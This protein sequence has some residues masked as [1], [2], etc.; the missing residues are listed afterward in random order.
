MKVPTVHRAAESAFRVLHVHRKAA[1]V[2]L[3]DFVIGMIRFTAATSWNPF[4]THLLWEATLQRVTQL[5]PPGDWLQY[6]TSHVITQG[7][8]KLWTAEW[9]CHHRLLCYSSQNDPGSELTARPGMNPFSVSQA[10]ESFWRSL[11]R[12]LPAQVHKLAITTVTEKVEH[13][14]ASLWQTNGWIVEGAVVATARSGHKWLRQRPDGVSGKALAGDPTWS[15]H[16]PAEFER[17]LKLPSARVFLAH[18]PENMQCTQLEYFALG[19]VA[20]FYS[21]PLESCSMAMDAATHNALLDLAKASTLASTKQALTALR[22]YAD[23]EPN[24]LSLRKAKALLFNVAMVFSLRRAGDSFTGAVR[25]SCPVHIKQGQCSHELY[26]RSLEGDSETLTQ[27]LAVATRSSK[28]KCQGRP[29]EVPARSA[30][31]T[32][33][34]IE[35]RARVRAEQAR[36]RKASAGVA[37]ESPAK[38]ARALSKEEKARQEL[39][40]RQTALRCWEQGLQSKDFSK[41]LEAVLS[42]EKSQARRAFVCACLACVR[43]LHARVRACACACACAR[44]CACVGWC[45]G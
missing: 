42:L 10:V 30:W 24:R 31:S 5:D 37:L 26:I 45:V 25:C 44:V 43:V 34:E 38:A 18:A 36:K 8:D 16:V 12:I 28:A 7:P 3:K 20:R 29:V 6:I 13:A 33:E 14:L 21:V 1:F 19:N 23:G 32:L 11:K 27:P 4:L 2:P 39:E 35:R 17:Q 40:K 15:D 22:C 9:L 41:R